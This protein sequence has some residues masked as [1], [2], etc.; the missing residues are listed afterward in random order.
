MTHISCLIGAGYS[1]VAGVPLAKNLL[2]NQWLLSLSDAR[3]RRFS[4]V[5]QH[6]KN[7][8]QRNPGRYSEEYLG[9]LSQGTLEN[10]PLWA[11]V[12]EYVAAVIAS[13]G[14]PPGS[15]NRNP[16]YSNRLNRRTDCDTHRR[17]WQ[18]VISARARLS[19][20]TTNYDILIERA[21]RHRPMIRPRSP[22][23]FYGGLTKPQI[24][25]GAAQ[26]FSRF[27][28][29]TTIIMN[30]EVP[31]YKLH[32]SLSWAKLGSESI[33]P[34]QDMRA[35]FRRGGEAAIVAPVPEKTVPD[36]L[37]S[38]WVDAEKSLAS[39]DTWLVVGYSL[40]PYDIEVN[41]MLRRAASNRELRIVLCDPYGCD[42]ASRWEKIAGSGNVHVLPG[43]PDCIPCLPHVLSYG[44]RNRIK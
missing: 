42:L 25:K 5:A 35:V 38:I 19:V 14:T 27:S 20:V 32:G 40:P 11:S 13:A 29:E 43:L 18:A 41:E 9:E 16:R 22:G 28:P 39:A 33:V 44:I 10:A 7:W 34:Y 26:P 23:C 24:L 37:K 36:W 31:V 1:H 21:L 2:K 15:L 6:Y 8:A 4:E 12:V 30:G 17:F 3:G